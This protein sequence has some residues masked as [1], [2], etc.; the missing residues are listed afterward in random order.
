[1][2]IINVQ[3]SEG[4]S[5]QALSNGACNTIVAKTVTKPRPPKVSQQKLN[6]D[7]NEANGDSA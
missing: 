1:M 2:W 7:K 3:V 6:T 4:S 5:P